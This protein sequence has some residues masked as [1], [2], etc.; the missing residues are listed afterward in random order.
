MVCRADILG[1]C[2]GVKRA[3]GMT[4]ALAAKNPGVRI[5][6]IGPLIHNPVALAWLAERGVEVL[7]DAETVTRTA[8]TEAGGVAADR[9]A[10]GPAPGILVIRA[11]GI[12]PAMRESLA[13]GG[14]RIVDATCPRVLRSQKIAEEYSAKGFQVIIVGDKS[15]GE[16]QGIR[17]YAE[18]ATVISSYEE[19]EALAVPSLVAVI[20]QTTFSKSEYRRICS[21]IRERN[22]E[23]VIFRSICP[24]TEQRQK[25]LSRLI[26]EV[27]GV[28][29]VGGR[30][31]ANTTRLFQTAAASGKPA[32]F[33]ESAA[34]IDRNERFP[35]RVGLTAG[36]STPDW[37]IDEVEE[38]ILAMDL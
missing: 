9:E 25:A 13:S 21:L 8:V 26:A 10:A 37:V 6:T 15:H 5:R 22:G 34:E 35:V 27:D 28:V 1:F 36:A 30:N 20:G 17:G 23:A 24:A 3:M 18:G 2:M 29:V 33:V 11:H 7:E 4:L 16:V 32:W 38:R 19:A 14:A 12:A 31:S